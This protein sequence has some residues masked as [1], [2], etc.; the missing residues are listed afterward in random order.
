ME[1][2]F[3]VIKHLKIKKPMK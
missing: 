2:P 3:V 1:N